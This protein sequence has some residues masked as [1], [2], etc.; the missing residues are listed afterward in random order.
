MRTLK[1]KQ[2]KR[3]FDITQFKKRDATE[4]QPNE[5]E[6][7]AAVFNSPAEIYDCFT[8]EIMP[9]A[10]TRTL[11]ENSDV[12]ALFN[13][14]WDIVLG[15][16]KA[17]T[18]WLEEDERGLKF[19]VSLPDTTAA[20]DLVKSMERGDINQCSFLFDTVVDE[21]DYSGEKPHCRVIEAKLYEIS[22]VSLPAYE[23]TEASLVRSKTIKEDVQK[24]MQL[25][26]K[27]NHILEGN[28]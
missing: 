21:W 28:K 27:I 6:G 1:N 2:V 22:I 13:H 25:V 23:D 20:Q 17:G 14:N 10:F 19:R 12:R 15:R 3:T 16:T 7:Y 5:I 4:G 18:L 9:G 26:K 24:R 8:E 11:S